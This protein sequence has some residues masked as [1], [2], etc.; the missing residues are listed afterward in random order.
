VEYKHVFL[1][2]T[3]LKK[4]FLETNYS[5]GKKCVFIPRSFLVINVCNQGET[6]CSPCSFGG[7]GFTILGLLAAENHPCIREQKENLSQ[8]R[9][10]VSLSVAVYS[11]SDDTKVSVWI[12]ALR[13][14]IRN[15]KL[16]NALR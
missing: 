5:N 6:L 1:N 7:I 2:V 12:V 8:V 13:V 4:F 10:R 9:K 16:Q 14:H 15:Q 3:Q 11:F